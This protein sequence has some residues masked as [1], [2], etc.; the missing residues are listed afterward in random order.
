MLPKFSLQK[1]KNQLEDGL[2]SV[3]GNADDLLSAIKNGKFALLLAAKL[4][5]GKNQHQYLCKRPSKKTATEN[6]ALER[7]VTAAQTH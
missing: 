2:T 3:S 5:Q 1:N 7:E 4:K 6:G